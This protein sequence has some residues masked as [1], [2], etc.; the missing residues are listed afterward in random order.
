[1]NSYKTLLTEMPINMVGFKGKVKSEE[2]RVVSAEIS[3][4]LHR[5]TDL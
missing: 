5:L 3:N 2:G 1:M 4:L